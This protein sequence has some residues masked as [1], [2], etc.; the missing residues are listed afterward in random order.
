LHL[1]LIRRPGVTSGLPR[2][3]EGRKVGVRDKLVIVLESNKVL[4]S[5]AI[6]Q[7]FRPSCDSFVCHHADGQASNEFLTNDPGRR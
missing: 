5:E 2:L 6:E 7:L 3:V 4:P 1:Q